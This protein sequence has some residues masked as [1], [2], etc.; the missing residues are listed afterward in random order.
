MELGLSERSGGKGGRVGVGGVGIRWCV[1]GKR[2]CGFA[3]VAECWRGDHWVGI[4]VAEAIGVVTRN[5]CGCS[6]WWFWGLSVED[7]FRFRGRDF[8]RRKIGSD[9]ESSRRGE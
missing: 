6:R 1:R 3:L 5:H 9:L 7:K 4:G 8:W 2:R